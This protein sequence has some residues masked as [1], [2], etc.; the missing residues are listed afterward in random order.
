MFSPFTFIWIL[1]HFGLL[2]VKN[3][4]FY[5][6]N[7]NSKHLWSDVFPWRFT[8]IWTRFC[9][10]PVRIII[11]FHSFQLPCSQLLLPIFIISILLSILLSHVASHL[12]PFASATATIRPQ[13]YSRTLTTNQT[14]LQHF[15]N[16]SP[17]VLFSQVYSVDNATDYCCHFQCWST[18]QIITS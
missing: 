6:K 8:C 12:W 14:K 17:K 13:P 2:L 4:V 7:L 9:P 15:L 3:V 10:L 5:I 18:F 1:F 16:S 11:I